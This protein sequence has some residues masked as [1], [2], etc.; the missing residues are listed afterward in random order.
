MLKR[1]YKQ[2]S[3]NY[4]TKFI[5]IISNIYKKYILFFYPFNI[6]RGWNH[7]DTSQVPPFHGTIHVA[8]IP[9]QIKREGTTKWGGEKD[10]NQ[11]VTLP[12]TPLSHVYRDTPLILSK[13]EWVQFTKKSLKLW[14]SNVSQE[15]FHLKVNMWNREFKQDSIQHKVNQAEGM[16]D[17]C[18]VRFQDW[19]PDNDKSIVVRFS[20]AVRSGA[21]YTQQTSATTSWRFMFVYVPLLMLKGI[22]NKCHV[23]I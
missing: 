18:L 4:L 10:T 22:T 23:I 16:P 9:P 1:N 13:G 3:C 11:S 20:H 8:H 15:G 5:N 21:H 7:C 6:C 17:I 14:N 19:M 12:T 2:V